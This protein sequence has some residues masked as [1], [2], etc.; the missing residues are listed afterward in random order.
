MKFFERS[1]SLLD[2]TTEEALENE[3]IQIG[4]D[5]GFEQILM[6]KTFRLPVSLDTASILGNFS[7]KWFNYYCREQLVNIDPR[8]AHSKT[9]ST[10]LL[11]D[12]S[13]FVS[14]DQKEMYEQAASH[15]LSS[16]ITL[17]FHGAKG[18][19]GMLSFS[20]SAKPGLN[21]QRDLCHV[22]PILSMIRDFAFDASFR[23]AK[24]V[25]HEPTPP[26]TLRELECLKWCASGKSSW[27]ISTIFGCS[28]AAV[29]FHFSNLR[30]KFNVHSRRD[31]VV[32]AILHGLL[33]VR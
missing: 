5:L 22:L 1:L 21:T 11:W 27:E 32:K 3:V 28:E 4:S 9:H 14:K 25:N 10:P 6:A 30:R 17:P 16:G 23:F 2:C 12:P 13:I 20:T 18:E 19:V 26:I 33:N 15:G 8:V 31:V 24:R 7:D 29:N